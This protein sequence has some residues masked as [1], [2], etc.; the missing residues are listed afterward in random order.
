MIDY[1]FTFFFSFFFKFFY[2]FFFVKDFFIE[3]D[4]KIINK[5]DKTNNLKDYINIDD[6]YK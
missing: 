6:N 5:E 3:K 4:Y 1:T 2:Y